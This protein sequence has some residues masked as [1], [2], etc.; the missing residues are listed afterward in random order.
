MGARC[1]PKSIALLPR[2]VAA[3]AGASETAVLEMV[4]TGTSGTS[5]SRRLVERTPGAVAAGLPSAVRARLVA[6]FEGGDLNIGAGS[7]SDFWIPGSV[8]VG[9]CAGSIERP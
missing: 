6:T 1:R 3:A 4:T 9:G 7:G 2:V 8:L 5:P